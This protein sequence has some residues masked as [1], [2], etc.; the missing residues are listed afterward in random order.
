M[1][2]EELMSLLDSQISQLA[3]IATTSIDPC[4]IA[5]YI[6]ISDQRVK[7]KVAEKLSNDYVFKGAYCKSSEVSIPEQISVIFEFDCP[8]SVFCLIPGTFLV[9]VDLPSSSVTQIQDPYLG[10]FECAPRPERGRMR[11]MANTMCGTCGRNCCPN[12][13]SGG[14]WQNCAQ[15]RFTNCSVCGCRSNGHYSG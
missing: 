7:D 3:K 10:K 9:I 11:I 13:T 1:K 15:T 8:S 6:A 14:N 4:L 2:K 5:Q 12:C